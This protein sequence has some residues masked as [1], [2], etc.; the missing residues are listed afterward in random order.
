M[1][2][3]NRQINAL[4]SLAGRAQIVQFVG[5]CLKSKIKEK[6]NA[7]KKNQTNK[8]TNLKQT[9]ATCDSYTNQNVGLVCNGNGVCTSAEN[10]TCN[11]GFQGQYCGWSF[12]IPHFPISSLVNCSSPSLS[13]SV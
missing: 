9:K 2:I 3:A 1:A 11:A 6:S 4:V 10:C 8:Q 13:V 7:G 12:A 5:L